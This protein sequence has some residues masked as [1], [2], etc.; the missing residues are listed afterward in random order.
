MTFPELMHVANKCSDMLD[1]HA[2]LVRLKCPQN[3]EK[4]NYTCLPLPA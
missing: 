4:K 2:I 3:K 1:D